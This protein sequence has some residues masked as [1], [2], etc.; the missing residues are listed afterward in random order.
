MFIFGHLGIGRTLT[1]P[2]QH[3]YSPWLLAIGMLLPDAIDK[4]LY[5]ARISDFFSCTR[6]VGHTGIL[7]IAVL[8][9][10]RLFRSRAVVA[11]GLGMATH[12]AL[13]C[14][15][16][17]VAADGQSSTW[18]AVIWPLLGPDFAHFYSASVGAHL[19]RLLTTPVM[20][21]EAIGVSLLGWDAWRARRPAR[22]I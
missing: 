13:D 12:L 20:A 17:F 3:R 10:G 11:I 21:F 7:L 16:D 14:L 5:Y 18:R 22:V 6:T 19:W 1:R 4:P 2:W 8:S 15:I 9:L